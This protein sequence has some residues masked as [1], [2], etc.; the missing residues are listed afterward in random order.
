MRNFFQDLGVTPST[1]PEALRSAWIAKRKQLHGDRTQQ[2]DSE[3]ERYVNMAYM[4]LKDPEQHKLHIRQLAFTQD[5]CSSCRA[6]GQVSTTISWSVTKFETCP[7]CK[8]AG[9]FPRK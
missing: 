1:E 9:Y 7:W 8:G 3:E 5:A 4:A 6:T 2:W